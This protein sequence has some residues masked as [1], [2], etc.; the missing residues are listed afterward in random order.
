MFSNNIFVIPKIF[1]NML[2]GR[3]GNL[4]EEMGIGAASTRE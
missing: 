1:I 2:G 4:F 3:C